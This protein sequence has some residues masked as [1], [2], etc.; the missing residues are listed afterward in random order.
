MVIVGGGIYFFHRRH[1]NNLAK[2]KALEE[3]RLARELFEREMRI[4]EEQARA[5]AEQA[6]ITLEIM[7]RNAK[8][9][10]NI[11]IGVTATVTSVGIGYAIY[12][13]YKSIVTSWQ[14]KKQEQ[15]LFAAKSELLNALATANHEEIGQFELPTTCT[16]RV[17]KL[18]ALPGGK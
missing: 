10:N 9:R 7:Q 15:E 3:A 2:L 6:R 8:I 18:L 11:I 5:A 16:P 4:K 12:R 14:Q 17:C 1:V 13:L